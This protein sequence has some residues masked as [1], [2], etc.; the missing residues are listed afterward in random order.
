MFF[1]VVRASGTKNRRRLTE[2]ALAEGKTRKQGAHILAANVYPL[3]LSHASTQPGL[4]D[5]SLFNIPKRGETYLIAT[6][7]PKGHEIYQMDKN[8]FRLAIEYTNF[9]HSNALQN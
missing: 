8:L 7:L 3:N 6:K 5:F 1:V 9:I 4:P 2:A